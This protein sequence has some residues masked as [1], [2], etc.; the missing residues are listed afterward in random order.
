MQYIVVSAVALASALLTLF[1]GFGLG[2]LLLPAFAVFF[3]LEIAVAAT[4]VVHLLNNL[5]KVALLGKHARRDIVL[6]FGI[7]A[8]GFA[9]LGAWVLRRL[10]QSQP[11]HSYVLGDTL[12]HV[13]PIGL[14]LGGLIALFA[15]LEL[16][17]R[18][19]RLQ[20]ASRWLPAGGALSGFFGGLSGHQGALR[21]AFLARSGL[22]RD[23][24]LGTSVICA[25]I[26]DCTRLAVYGAGFYSTHFDSVRQSGGHTLVAVA[27]LAAFLGSFLGTRLVRKVTMRGLQ[28]FIGVTMLVLSVAIAAGLV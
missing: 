19:E 13:T 9:F 20:F 17:P 12:H 24:F 3:P 28:R 27:T 10:A 1:S 16:S 22:D 23:A 15:L 8:A 25:V 18:I 14:V 2:S 6:R 7:A 5:F 4:A 26:V 11:I 21:A